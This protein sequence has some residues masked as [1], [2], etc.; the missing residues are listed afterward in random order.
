[1]NLSC[2]TCDKWNQMLSNLSR[3]MKL[4]GHDDVK[5]GKVDCMANEGLCN[6][7]YPK[8]SKLVFGSSDK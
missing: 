8:T 5:I 4:S 2:E 6:E 3:E 7:A 1:M